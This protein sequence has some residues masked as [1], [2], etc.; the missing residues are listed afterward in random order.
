MSKLSRKRR[1]PVTST[2][3]D[4]PTNRSGEDGEGS[5][6]SREER[7]FQKQLEMAT[8]RSLEDLSSE[9]NDSQNSKSAPPPSEPTG[10]REQVGSGS[11]TDHADDASAKSEKSAEITVEKEVT[12][13]SD[14][15]SLDLEP[16][17][18]PVKPKPN[19]KSRVANNKRPRVMSDSDDS[20]DD[21]FKMEDQDDSDDDFVGFSG[22]KKNGKKDKASK[23]AKTPKSN[24][25][26]TKCDEVKSEVKADQPTKSKRDRTAVVKLSPLK[27]PVPAPAPKKIDNVV[28]PESKKVDNNI[29]KKKEKENVTERKIEVT[30]KAVGPGLGAKPVIKHV[31]KWNPPRKSESSPATSSLSALKLSPGVRLGLSRNFKTTKPLHPNVKWTQ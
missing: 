29:S 2:Q 27:A 31:P 4:N 18:S 26:K 21:D 19:P 16:P 8:K 5:Y 3:L 13:G 6:L 24:N 28:P 30:P 20:D 11:K 15:P 22:T 1:G 7:N 23:K 12:R 25:K 10:D 17:E 14:E 9:E